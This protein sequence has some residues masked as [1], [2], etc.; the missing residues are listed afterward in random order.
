M[1]VF[2][3]ARAQGIVRSKQ[4]HRR[5]FSSCRSVLSFLVEARQ[6]AKAL[7]KERS[8]T[9]SYYM[10]ADP[11]SR[12]ICGCS[13]CLLLYRAPLFCSI[14]RVGEVLSASCYLEMALSSVWLPCAVLLLQSRVSCMPMGNIPRPRTDDQAVSRSGSSCSATQQ[15]TKRRLLLSSLSSSHPPHFSLLSTLSSF[16]VSSFI[17]LPSVLLST[18]H[19]L[20]IGCYLLS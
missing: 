8:S 13:G 16:R 2:L 17:L 4:S 3:K 14:P 6:L 15:C 1:G 19:R 18:S 10:Q 11:R 9:S 20:A 5:P 12:L 7:A